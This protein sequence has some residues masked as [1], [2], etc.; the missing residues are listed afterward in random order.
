[1]TSSPSK[2]LSSVMLPIAK[3]LR[4]RPKNSVELTM[5][6]Y[7]QRNRN[8][9]TWFSQAFYSHPGGYKFCLS[10]DANGY[11]D[12]EGTHISVYIRLMQGE[13]DNHLNWPLQGEFAIQILNKSN[14]G[15][16]KR[17]RYNSSPSNRCTTR[18]LHREIS[19][20]GGGCRK[21]IS[22][23]KVERKYLRN[24]CLYFCIT[25]KNTY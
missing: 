9:N 16:V 17:I 4:I 23:H 10:V 1:M 24:D 8:G 21:F 12:A 22:Q 2:T 5:Q 15:H 18:V 19:E 14:R 25:C 13:F 6:N 7:E 3:H 20:H 11:G